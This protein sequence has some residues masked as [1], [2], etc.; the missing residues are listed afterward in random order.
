M[1]DLPNIDI[2][3][4]PRA[5]DLD[6]KTDILAAVVTFLLAQRGFQ[7]ES[8]LL[9]ARQALGMVVGEGRRFR[10]TPAG[11][12]WAT[13]LDTAPLA[14]NGWMLWNMLG[15][16][17]LVG[18]IEDPGGAPGDMLEQFLRQLGE[19]QMQD[20]IALLSRLTIEAD[21]HANPAA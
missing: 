11:A 19:S 9:A 13:M 18:T 15:L 12:Q 4:L 1:K 7:T 17:R 2:P 8:G 20:L 16:D 14:Q 5:W 6:S 3:P 10:A 21:V